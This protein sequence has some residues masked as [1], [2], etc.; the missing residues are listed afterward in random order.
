MS[1][2]C[3]EAR[4]VRALDCRYTPFVD[5]TAGRHRNSPA[6]APVTAAVALL[7]TLGAGRAHAQ[8]PPPGRAAGTKDGATAF[9]YSFLG[10]GL[11]CVAS[12]IY[13]SRD[14]EA[15]EAAA[16]LPVLAA[17]LVGPSLGHFY[18]GRPTRAWVG[19]GIRSAAAL[20]FAA[21]LSI[22][23]EK[24]YDAP[25]A[26]TLMLVSVL[27]G[28]SSAVVDIFEAPR[29]ARIHNDGLKGSRLDV[30]PGVIGVARV[31]GVR[32]TISF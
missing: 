11:P 30:A 20:G 13:I 18:A 21:G 9:A 23:T 5:P 3:G 25:S 8:D 32:A 31:P 19:I 1:E 4:S 10:T 28:L 14:G 12:S 17:Y 27:V 15:S 7:F 2:A 22:E 24:N 16:G 26:N 6:S 29:S